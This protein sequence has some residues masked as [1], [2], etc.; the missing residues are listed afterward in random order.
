MLY[1]ITVDAEAD[2]QIGGDYHGTWVVDSPRYRVQSPDGRLRPESEVADF[3]RQRALEHLGA[4]DAYDA[5]VC[6]AEFYP[7]RLGHHTGKPS[8]MTSSIGTFVVS[9]DR[10]QVPA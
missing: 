9:R 5:L 7:V 2:S 8:N 4:S 10:E 1:E 3:A 6:V